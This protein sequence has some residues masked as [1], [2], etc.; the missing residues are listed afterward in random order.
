MIQTLISFAFLAITGYF[1]ARLLPNS[2]K[3]DNIEKITL[4]FAFSMALYPILL[5][6]SGVYLGIP[7]SLTTLL[8]FLITLILLVFK[9]KPL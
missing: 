3:M 5:F 1:M 6:V 8:A 7:V 9:S 4:S 2:K